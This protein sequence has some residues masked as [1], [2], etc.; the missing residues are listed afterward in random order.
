[1]WKMS[2]TVARNYKTLASDKS[3]IGE[4]YLM[5]EGFIQVNSEFLGNHSR[6]FN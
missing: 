1:M 3:K 2:R 5:Y 4:S 6:L